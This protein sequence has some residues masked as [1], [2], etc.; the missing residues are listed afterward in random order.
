M[1]RDYHGLCNQDY[2]GN[3]DY[4]IKAQPNMLSMV[5]QW[6]LPLQW[7]NGLQPNG[8]LKSHEVKF[9]T[10]YEKFWLWNL[11]W[12]NKE[13]AMTQNPKWVDVHIYAWHKLVNDSN[14]F[15]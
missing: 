9:K 15:L 11:K 4:H 7:C 3:L 8:F 6:G 2:I 14:H 1:F 10:V 5:M 12:E 13:K